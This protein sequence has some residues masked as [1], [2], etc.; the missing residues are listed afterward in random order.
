MRVVV[1]CAAGPG[2]AEE[3]KAGELPGWGVPEAAIAKVNYLLP[4]SEVAR[5]LMQVCVCSHRG[6]LMGAGGGGRQ[7]T[8]TLLED[9]G[10]LRF[11]LLCGTPSSEGRQHT[12]FKDWTPHMCIPQ[13]V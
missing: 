1:C 2:S 13:A 6:S 9:S 12:G 10:A 3:L 8:Y 4:R 7:S 11:L 5:R